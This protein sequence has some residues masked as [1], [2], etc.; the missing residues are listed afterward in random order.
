[1]PRTVRGRIGFGGKTVAAPDLF[2]VAI[3]TGRVQRRV[4][5]IPRSAAPAATYGVYVGC[6]NQSRGPARNGWTA[7]KWR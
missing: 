6:G 3:P 4:G 7:G 2:I 5:G 1:M